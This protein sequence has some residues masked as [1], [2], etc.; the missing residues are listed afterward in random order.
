MG[1]PEM[2]GHALV[3]EG[4]TDARGTDAYNDARSRSRPAANGFPRIFGRSDRP[5]T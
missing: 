5:Q 2:E 1:L 4:H 3:I